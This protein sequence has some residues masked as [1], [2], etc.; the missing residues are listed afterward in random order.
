MGKTRQETV[1]NCIYFHF[2][3][4]ILRLCWMMALEASWGYNEGQNHHCSV[5]AAPVMPQE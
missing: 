2:L 3:S 1:I 4:E 5:T